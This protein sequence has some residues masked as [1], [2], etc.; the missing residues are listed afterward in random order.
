MIWEFLQKLRCYTIFHILELEMPQMEWIYLESRKRPPPAQIILFL[1][2]RT[3]F[4]FHP[5]DIVPLL[6]R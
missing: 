3:F 2:N 4:K 1:K 5:F 6:I